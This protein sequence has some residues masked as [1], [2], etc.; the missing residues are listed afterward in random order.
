MDDGMKQSF[1][2]MGLKDIIVMSESIVI[3]IT[4]AELTKKVNKR[5]EKGKRINLRNCVYKAIL[6]C[7][8]AAFPSFRYVSSKY[9]LLHQVCA[10][11]LCY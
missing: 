5:R 3:S 7:R 9:L 8:V 11:R 4:I 1:M 2:N 6:H 10:K